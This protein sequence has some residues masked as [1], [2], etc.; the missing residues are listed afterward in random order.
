MNGPQG[1]GDCSGLVVFG[2]IGSDFEGVCWFSDEPEIADGEF[3]EFGD[4]E[5]S[6]G[7]DGEEGVVI[8]VS[9]VI[10]ELLELEGREASNR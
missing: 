8:F 7:K 9:G 3:A 6:V 2:D 10:E 1:E 5:A 4:S